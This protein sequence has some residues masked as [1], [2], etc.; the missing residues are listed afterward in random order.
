[1]AKLPWVC[2]DYIIL[3]IRSLAIYCLLYIFYLSRHP[4]T[5]LI[6]CYTYQC[7]IDN[8]TV[9]PYNN[10]MYPCSDSKYK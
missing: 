8:S 2:I 4:V 5:V 1:M 9:L 7:L 3:L 6:A 10:V